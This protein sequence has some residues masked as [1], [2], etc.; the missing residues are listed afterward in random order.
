MNI[1]SDKL[2]NSSILEGFVIKKVTGTVVEIENIIAT[3]YSFHELQ[4]LFSIINQ[5]GAYVYNTIVSSK[6]IIIFLKDETD[7]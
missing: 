7:N 5:V 6:S 2:K 3:V 1:L 4:E